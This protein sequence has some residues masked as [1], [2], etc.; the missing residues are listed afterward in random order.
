MVMQFTDINELRRYID[1]HE[2]RNAFIGIAKTFKDKF[3]VGEETYSADEIEKLLSEDEQNK[4]IKV[5]K[6]NKGDIL[7]CK[8]GIKVR[9]VNYGYD[10]DLTLW[11]ECEPAEFKSITREFKE[12]DLFRV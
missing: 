7:M 6:Y 11:Y 3:I 1:N 5:N 4:E 9:V 8:Q 2:D 10:E 12:E